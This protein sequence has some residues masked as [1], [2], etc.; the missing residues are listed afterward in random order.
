MKLTSFCNR[1]SLELLFVIDNEKEAKKSVGNDKNGSF[2]V[3][4]LVAF[5][6]K[7]SRSTNLK[8]RSSAAVIN[9]DRFVT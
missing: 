9:V 1:N 3:T 4:A 2:C 7:Y 6:R 8:M 5:L